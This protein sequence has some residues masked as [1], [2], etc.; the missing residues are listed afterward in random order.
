MSYLNVSTPTVTCYIRNEFLFNH[1]KG[2]GEFTQCDIFG[3]ASIEHRVPLFHC[4]LENGAVWYRRP[5][6]AF[7][8]K[9][10]APKVELK[11]LV[12]WDCFSYYPT[13][14]TFNRLQGLRCKVLHR[15]LEGQYM[16]TIDWA[17]ADKSIVDFN[18]SEVAE[19]KSANLVK[20]D[21]GTFGLYPNNQVV[22][23]DKAF[24]SEPLSKNPGYQ[25][26]FN[27]YSV[28]NTKQRTEDSNN[29]FYKVEE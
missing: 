17:H 19:H 15:K 11:D 1:E 21:D 26:D 12:T 3:I 5:L 13:V 29:Y 24:V 27:T 25:I 2:H 23:F 14:T 20:L 28:E 22:F 10:D 9:K 18:F 16:F 4:L 6:H 8:W 7:V